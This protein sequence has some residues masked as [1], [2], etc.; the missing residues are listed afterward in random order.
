MVGY[1]SQSRSRGFDLG[2][3]RA[4]MTCVAQVEID[5]WCQKVLKKHWP[6]VPKFGDIRHVG[7]HNLPSADAIVGGFPCQPHSVAG[8]RKG[9]ADDRNLWPEYLRI[10]KE[11]K[12]RWVIGENVPGI[13]TTYLD[14]VLSDLES[15]NYEIAT[16]N[17]PACGFDA[18]H[19]RE[20][21][22]VVGYTKHVGFDAT[23]ITRS[24]AGTQQTGELERSGEQHAL[25]AD[26]KLNGCDQVE[27]PIVAGPNKKGAANTAKHSSVT[28]GGQ[29]WAAEP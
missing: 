24:E 3:E 18:P 13:I 28:G 14:T 26:A 22:F 17:L 25:M 5:E 23:K 27:Q 20:R 12:P 10:I 21:I 19:R 16:F 9:A 7:K 15:E 11:L 1:V 2:L 8:K 6:N 29:R 4:G